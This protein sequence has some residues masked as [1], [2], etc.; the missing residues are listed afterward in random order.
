MK[1]QTDRP[2]P[3][4]VTDLPIPYRLRVLTASAE[5]RA[6]VVPKLG[7]QPAATAPLPEAV[8]R[9]IAVAAHCDVRTAH[10]ALE[11]G[12]MTIR[13]VAVRDRVAFAIRRHPTI[14]AQYSKDH[15]P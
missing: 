5:L 2:I 10:R 9:T 4:V 1:T 15:Y 12:Y 14:V 11:H 6:F 13:R 8:A 7:I 3:Y